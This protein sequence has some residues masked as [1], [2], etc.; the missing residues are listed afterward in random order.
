MERKNFVYTL[1]ITFIVGLFIGGFLSGAVTGQFFRR[2]VPTTISVFPKEIITGH[3]STT[4]ELTIKITAGN[5]GAGVVYEIKRDDPHR[6]DENDLKMV[7]NQWCRGYDDFGNPVIRTGSEEGSKCFSQK[8]FTYSLPTKGF[9]KD[10]AYYIRVYDF[11]T[12]D[13]V[14]TYFKIAEYGSSEFGDSRS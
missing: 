3:T 6:D 9:F 2:P 7:E 13:Y 10:K 4:N 5:R 12:K 8:T 1:V 14:K 11:A